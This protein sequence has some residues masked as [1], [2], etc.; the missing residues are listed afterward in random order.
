MSHK[1][2]WKGVPW[3]ST[4]FAKRELA[5]RQFAVLLMAAQAA[6]RARIIRSTPG[7]PGE[8]AAALLALTCRFSSKSARIMKY[9][10]DSLSRHPSH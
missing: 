5:R 10:V 7:D 9:G 1:R 2:N 4:R 6:V 8:K 3:A